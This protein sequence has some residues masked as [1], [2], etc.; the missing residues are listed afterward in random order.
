M[1]VFKVFLKLHKQDGIKTAYQDSM[2]RLGIFL[3]ISIFSLKAVYASSDFKYIKNKSAN[4]AV[5]KYLSSKTL[6]NDLN[7]IRRLGLSL[8]TKTAISNIALTITDDANSVGGSTDLYTRKIHINVLKSELKCKELCFRQVLIH[9]IG[10][11]VFMDYL[12]GKSQLRDN[13]YSAHVAPANETP[14]EEDARYELITAF[15]WII[16]AYGE[17]A[18]DLVAISVLKEPGLGHRRN[19]A[20]LPTETLEEDYESAHTLF[21]AAR[22]VVWQKK[23]APNINNESKLF[24]ITN[25]LFAFINV[26]TEKQRKKWFSD[27]MY[28]P[29]PKQNIDSLK[30]Y[31]SL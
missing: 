17:F 25:D 14:S 13:R 6:Q 30:E 24:Q 10:H 26:E 2:I 8:Q 31:I 28:R 22:S 1:R 3:I 11:L 29:S 7:A 18:A 23:L 20:K 5:A 27:H 16:P 9:E 12:A 4:P 21:N 15:D 19:F